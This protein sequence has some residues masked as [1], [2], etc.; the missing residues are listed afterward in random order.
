MSFFQKSPFFIFIL[1]QPLGLWVHMQ[2]PGHCGCMGSHHGGV[3]SDFRCLQSSGTQWGG[4]LGGLKPPPPGPQMLKRSKSQ[5]PRHISYNC[6]G[7]IEKKYIDIGHH[8]RCAHPLPPPPFFKKIIDVPLVLD[9]SVRDPSQTSVD[10][11][12]GYKKQWRKRYY[13][14]LV[15]H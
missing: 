4:G 11:E 5:P 8:F 13:F 12:C 10:W 15:S 7:E 2:P 9:A 3:W 14:V 6:I 1:C